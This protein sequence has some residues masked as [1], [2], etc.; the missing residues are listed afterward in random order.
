MLLSGIATDKREIDGNI[1]LV[2][3]C[4]P[5]AADIFKDDPAEDLGAK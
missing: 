2:S 4:Y 3:R 1:P 5:L